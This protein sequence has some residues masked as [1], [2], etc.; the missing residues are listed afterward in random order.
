MSSIVL[1]PAGSDS[2]SALGDLVE[3][4]HDLNEAF[5]R[6]PGRLNFCCLLIH[7]LSELPYLVL[8]CRVVDTYLLNGA[9]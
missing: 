6:Q 5:G 3:F 2:V 9:D 1:T 4:V 8:E 7:L